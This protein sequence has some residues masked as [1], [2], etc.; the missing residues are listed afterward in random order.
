MSRRSS[1]GSE[2]PGAGVVLHLDAFSGIAGNMFVGALL[3]AGLSRRQ[4]TADLAGLGL[5]HSLRVSRVRRG[6]L[7][8]Y[9]VD[10]RVPTRG[11]GP[12][13]SSLKKRSPDMFE[14]CS[15]Y[16]T[17]T[18]LKRRRIAGDSGMGSVCACSWART[19]RF[20]TSSMHDSPR[21]K[22]SWRPMRRW[23]GG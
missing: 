17:T 10:V 6:A 2:R 18:S 11:T 5:E 22:R 12:R 4:L 21:Q 13:R 16:S 7:S 9:Y 3:D 23:T 19:I 1:T 20:G 15:R 8:G 14:S